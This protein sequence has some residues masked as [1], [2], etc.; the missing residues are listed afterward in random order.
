MKVD[1]PFS[2]AV[3]PRL[4]SMPN[5]C[6]Q[7]AR[8]KWNGIPPKKTAK[9]GI[10]RKL[11]HRDRTSTISERRYRRMARQMLDMM[12]NTTTSAIRTAWS[13]RRTKALEN[14]TN[15]STAPRR[16]CSRKQRASTKEEPRENLRTCPYLHS[17]IRSRGSSEC[18]EEQQTQ[19]HS[20]RR[21]IR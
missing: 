21:R 6:A 13:Q 17:A 2:L 14:Y 10:Q 18:R 11:W 7:M 15:H 5:M 12:L 20:T 9:N 3:A 4:M 1:L 16:N 8:S 19:G